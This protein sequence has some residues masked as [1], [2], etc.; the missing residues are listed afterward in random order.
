MKSQPRPLGLGS[1]AAIPPCCVVIFLTNPRPIPASAIRIQGFEHLK[2][3]FRV[4][5]LDA[6]AIVTNPEIPKSAFCPSINFNPPAGPVMVFDAVRDEIPHYKRELY[7]AA[8][9]RRQFRCH[10]DRKSLWYFADIDTFFYHHC[11]IEL[12]I[13]VAHVGNLRKFQKILQESVHTA[14]LS[15]NLQKIGLDR[16]GK[17]SESTF[18]IISDPFHQ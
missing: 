16:L 18:Q 10:A 8:L 4:F 17:R 5:W 12:F 6:G 1:T 7:R 11:R 9:N 14:T 13:G 3:L 2:D 15:R